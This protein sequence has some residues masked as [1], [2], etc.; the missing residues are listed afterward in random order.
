M[1]VLFVLFYK[2]GQPR[3]LRKAARNRRAVRR[4]LGAAR[5]DAGRRG[6]LGNPCFALR[7]DMLVL[8]TDGVADS[9]EGDKLSAAVNSLRT[10]NPQTLSEGILQHTLFNCG[11]RPRDDSTVLAARIIEVG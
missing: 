4:R 2:I 6:A 10:L 8:A 7:G 1:F 3:E 9:F 5:G 11:G